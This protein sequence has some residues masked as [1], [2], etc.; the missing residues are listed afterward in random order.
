MTSGIQRIA[1]ALTQRVDHAANDIAR[2]VQGQWRSW[3]EAI[4]YSRELAAQSQHPR[5]LSPYETNSAAQELLERRMA[6]SS[7]LAADALR[8]TF[9]IAVWEI[10]A[11]SPT[12]MRQ[13]DQF[14]TQGQRL[15]WGRLAGGSGF[16]EKTGTI[17]IDLSYSASP[18]GVVR[19]LAHESRHGIDAITRRA[20]RDGEPRD[21]WVDDHVN[22]YLAGEGAAVCAQLRV[23]AEILA[24]GG[25][26]IGG[27][28]GPNSAVYDQIFQRYRSGEITVVECERQLTDLYANEIPRIPGNHEPY[29]GYYRML[30]AAEWEVRYAPTRDASDT[31]P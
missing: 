19:V 3:R 26:D 21:E 28:P 18:T 13:V 22:T 6:N 1:R 23:R 12:L 4:V 25:P 10:G 24:A 27:V 30:M 9:G 8:N 11:L 20:P 15:R 29:R 17:V 14:L 16:D 5:G 31:A 7:I 2:T